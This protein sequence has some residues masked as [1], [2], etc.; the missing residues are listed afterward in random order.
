MK[1]QIAEVL[2]RKYWI[3]LTVV[4]ILVLAN[5]VLVQPYLIQLTTDAPLIN[6]AGRQRM[7]SQRLA[8]TALAFGDGRG[9]GARAYLEEMSE[10]LGLWTDAQERLLEDNGSRWGAG[11]NSA[12]VRD[13]L[14]GLEPLFV[15][16]RDAA[17]QMIR[18][19][20]GD[21]PDL[22]AVGDA[23]AVILQNEAE[24]LRRMDRVVGLYEAEARGRV[25][26]LRRVGWVVTGLILA[27]LAAIGRFILR[28]AAELIRRQIS[29][30]RQARDELEAR[31]RDRTREL[32]FAGERHRALVEQFS[33][34]A[35]TTTIGEMASG[36]AHE[37]NQPLGAIANYAEGCL[38]ELT[39]PKPA[40]NEVRT[41]LERL[42]ATTLRAGQIIDRI[43][44]FVTRHESRHE[45]FEA[46]RVVEEVQ[47]IL[48]AE[49]EERRIAVRLE[50]APDLPYL[51]GDSVQIQQVLVNLARN[52]FEALATQRV[53]P[54]LLMQTRLAESG[55]VEFAVIDNGEGI[56]PGC[57]DRVF[58]AYFSTRAGG[59]GMG[60]AICRT[61]IEAHQG[62][63]SVTSS[64]GVRTT[65]TFTLPAGNS[66]DGAVT[67]LHSG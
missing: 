58:D 44:K 43:R 25:D 35:R 45:R 30:L 14:H 66:D 59:M 41:A 12:A 22:A 24:Y 13:G 18:A 67:S 50:L 20:E 49:A 48:R 47:E 63:I 52:A 42:L 1:E 32:E 9:E 10:V 46:N 61:L 53:Q 2:G 11:G 62:R 34:V 21:R 19:G 29:E 65:F 6:L 56:N 16:M 40:L 31:V 57:L 60:L 36:L 38:V 64:P 23:R 8:K 33:H 55:G 3:A 51:F 4:A 37:L 27:T 54:T 5:Q 39:A 15:K 7:L 17:Q 26:N 28:P